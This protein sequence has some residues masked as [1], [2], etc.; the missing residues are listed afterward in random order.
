M[1]GDIDERL[2]PFIPDYR[3]NLVIPDE[4]ED[5]DI[6]STEL[7]EVLE[8]IKVSTDKKEMETL[9]NTNKKLSVM[10]SESVNAINIFTGMNIL[11]NEKEGVTDMCKAWEEQKNEFPYKTLS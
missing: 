8:F 6:F 9:L 10:S 2:I 7:G 4:I 1:F 11:V 3:I 5:F